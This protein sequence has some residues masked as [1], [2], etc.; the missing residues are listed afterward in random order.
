MSN[1]NQILH[2]PV[3]EINKYDFAGPGETTNILGTDGQSRFLGQEGKTITFSADNV[4]FDSS[5]GTVHGGVFQ[6]VQTVA[7][8]T[9]AP[10]VGRVAYWS[11]PINYVV[12]PD[13]PTAGS[14]IA[15]VYLNAATKG[16]WTFIQVEGLAEVLCAASL[17][18]TGAAGQIVQVHDRC[19]W[20][21]CPGCFGS[22]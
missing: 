9:A 18:T 17:T 16:N 13:A 14:Q 20:A 12:T 5:V 11:D 3:P 15:G 8:S 22:G 7:G 1:N 19:G 2:L 4:K 10:A 6:L 21:D